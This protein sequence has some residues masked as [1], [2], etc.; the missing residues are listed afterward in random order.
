MR[1]VSRSVLDGEKSGS[2]ALIER[3]QQDM[4]HCSRLV[5]AV[6]RGVVVV[7]VVQPVPP[8][9]EP[10]APFLRPS[11]HPFDMSAMMLRNAMRP[12]LRMNP[13]TASKRSVHISNEVGNVRSH[14]PPSTPPY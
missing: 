9:F 12:T 4:L 14:P 2:Y 13:I 7:V 5:R 8:I 11:P 10:F 6:P 3:I 1:R